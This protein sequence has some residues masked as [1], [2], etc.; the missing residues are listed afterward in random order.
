MKIMSPE[1]G[2]L[3]LLV[4]GLAMI[5]ITAWGGSSRTGGDPFGFWEPK[6]SNHSNFISFVQAIVKDLQ[7][8]QSKSGYGVGGIIWEDEY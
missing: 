7:G 6:T 5:I 2:Y 1:L 8:G 3:N 4:F